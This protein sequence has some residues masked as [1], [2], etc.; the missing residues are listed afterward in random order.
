MIES[1]KAATLR[2]VRSFGIFHPDK[3]VPKGELK[4]LI[5]RRF[6]ISS[7]DVARLID[8]LEREKRVAQDA[9]T[10]WLLTPA[11]KKAKKKA[12]AKAASR[13]K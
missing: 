4:E 5:A 3:K 7:P 12:K 8:T 9:S 1:A 11:K 6:L 13:P 10:V 2:S